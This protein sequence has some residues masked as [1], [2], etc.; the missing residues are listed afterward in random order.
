LTLY[1]DNSLNLLLTFQKTNLNHTIFYNFYIS[2]SLWELLSELW[3][4]TLY[5][6]TLVMNAKEKEHKL[7]MSYLQNHHIF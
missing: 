5:K 2:T 1:F 6:G 4:W 3:L 7:Q